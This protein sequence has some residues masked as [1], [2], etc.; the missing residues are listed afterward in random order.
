MKKQI[1]SSRVDLDHYTGCLLGGAVGDALGAPVEFL[2]LE[3]IRANYGSAGVTGYIHLTAQ[4]LAAFTDATQMTLFTAEGILDALKAGKFLSDDPSRLEILHRAYLRWLATQDGVD[5][6]DLSDSERSY[7]LL[8]MPEMNH[9]C[10]PGLTCL[11]ALRSG[12]L[13]TMQSPGNNS[14]GCGGIMRAAPA[15]MLGTNRAACHLGCEA[16]ALTHGHPSGYLSSGFLASIIADILSGLDLPESIDDG[17]NILVTYPEHAE[18]LRAVQA[19]LE[20]HRGTNIPTPEVVEN[21]GQGWVGEEALS[22]SLFCA[23]Q[24]G[25]DFRKGVLLAVNHSGDSDSTGAITGNILGALLGRSAILVE[26]LEKI[27]L[28]PVIEAMAANLLAYSD[29]GRN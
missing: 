8:A 19:A 5:A 17:M 16:A 21:L 14:K 18:V 24:A 20:L 22:I 12:K 9:Q 3:A 29:Q 11:N 1:F 2:S 10:A 7:G 28:R 26:W 25:D 6:V 23:L 15:G 27:E 13:L 4:D